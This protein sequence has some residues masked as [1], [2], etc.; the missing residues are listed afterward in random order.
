MATPIHQ[1]EECYSDEDDDFF[2][3]DIHDSTHQESEKNLQG[4]VMTILK[5]LSVASCI[6]YI[7]TSKE[8]VPKTRILE[9]RMTY[10][11]SQLLL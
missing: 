5:F 7:C 11:E 1:Q 9:E 3:N 4:S 6:Q 2:G 10:I 8:Y